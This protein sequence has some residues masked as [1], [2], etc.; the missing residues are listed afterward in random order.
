MK[1]LPIFALLSSLA[2]IA[3]A[4]TACVPSAY[5]RPTLE[6]KHD[7][8]RPDFDSVQLTVPDA[9]QVGP[10]TAG[11]FASAGADTFDIW[12]LAMPPRGGVVDDKVF[13]RLSHFSPN[14]WEYLK[15][16]P[17]AFLID[18]QPVNPGETEHDGTVGRGYVSEYIKFVAPLDLVDRMARGRSVEGELCNTEFTF[19]PET[20]RLMRDFV[21]TVRTGVVPQQPIDPREGTLEM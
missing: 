9:L 10:A 15:C 11:I 6:V 14:G 2:L 13:F 7:K 20:L 5:S 12:L 8:F 1:L 4:N 19:K 16:H 3:A 18:G 21:S 17:L